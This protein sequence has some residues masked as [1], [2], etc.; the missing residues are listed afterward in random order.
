M[1]FK[2][3][4]EVKESL[5]ETFAASDGRAWDP[6]LKMWRFPVELQKE[7]KEWALRLFDESEIHFPGQAGF[8][9]LLLLCTG[10]ALV[11]LPVALPGGVL[12]HRLGIAAQTAADLDLSRAI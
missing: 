1:S 3:T 6:D 12:L 7:V 9:L 8:C 4:E 11:L 2:Y 5:K 10:S